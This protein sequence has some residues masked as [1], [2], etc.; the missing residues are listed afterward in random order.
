VKKLPE[1]FLR[2]LEGIKGFNRQTF[3]QVHEEGQQVTSVRM[4]PYKVTENHGQW[5]IDH[6]LSSSINRIPWSRYGYY[7]S[8]RPSFTFDPLFHAGCYYVQEASSMF[9]E[10]AFVQ[11]TD[12]SEPLKVL[13]LC[14]APGGKST[15]IQSLISPESILVCNEVISSRTNILTDNILKW[16]A[17]NVVVTN[18]DPSAFSRLEG[19]FD[20][21]VVDAP[22]SGS[23]LFRKDEESIDEWS[24]HNV[25]LCSQRQQRILAD[26]LPALKPGGILIYSTCSYSREEDEYITS[27]LVNEMNMENLKLQVDPSWEIV[28]AEEND[29]AGFRFYP[30]KLKGE[31]LY[32]ACFRKN[33]GSQARFRSVKIEKASANEKAIIS[34]A[35]KESG[36]EIIKE[37]NEF[38][39][40][41]ETLFREYGILKPALNTRY[42]GTQLGAIMKKRLVPNHA[43]ALSLIASPMLPAFDVSY[44]EAIRYLQRQDTGLEFP[45]KGWHLIRYQTHNLGWVNVLGNRTNNYYPKELRILKQSG[46]STF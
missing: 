26:G 37:N 10:Q 44:E 35:V 18:N 20:V 36:M 43:L 6:N 34:G 25:Q 12:I 42:R 46:H 41:P 15:H 39:S 2:S 4:N 38:F 27:W 9:L 16:G 5:T 29:V 17:S 28:T 22:C 14:A 45:G 24:L 30:D 3:V 21:M 8:S 40:L 19:Y 1:E 11:L 32:M 13:D 33:D 23:G 7:L 31:G